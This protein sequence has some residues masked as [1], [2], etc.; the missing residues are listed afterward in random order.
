MRNPEALWTTTEDCRP[1]QH[2]ISE[3]SMQYTDGNKSDKPLFS[4]VRS[5]PRWHL[6]S[7]TLQCSPGLY[8]DTD[9]TECAA[10]YTMYPFLTTRRSR[11]SR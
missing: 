8:N 11:L 7:N 6:I 2:S 1:H 10:W 4:K 9:N 3:L 5:S